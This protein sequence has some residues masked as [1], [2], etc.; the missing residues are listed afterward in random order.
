VTDLAG[1]ASSSSALEQLLAAKEVVVVC[2]A[3]GVG[4][5]TTAAALGVLAVTAVGG[6][7]LVL[8]VDPAR[9]LADAMGVG[10]LGN[11]AVRIPPEMFAGTGV[12][13]EG[14]LWAAMLDTKGGWDDLV[15]LHAPDAATRDAILGNPLYDTL[16]ARFVQSHDYVAMERLYE[17]HTSGDYDLV[18]VDTPPSRHAIDFLEAPTRMAEFFASRFLRLLIAP[19]RARIV[20]LAARPFYSLADRILGGDFVRDIAEFFLAFQSM[21]EGFIG[22][23]RAVE[24]L[25][26]EP[27]TAFVVVSTLE[28]APLSESTYLLDELARRRLPVGAVILNKALPPSLLDRDAAEA[29]AWLRSDAARAVDGDFGPPELVAN[30]LDE[31][32]ESFGRL[33]VIAEREVQH[34]GEMAGRA[35]VVVAVPQLDRDIGDLEGLLAIA[36]RL[37]AADS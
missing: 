28:P 19:K 8:T 25:L 9:R 12:H 36:D 16:T 20:N 11:D 27:R 2:G 15:R 1:P 10:A 6:R 34:R 37:R 26:T 24:R 18:I 32:G 4:K 23:A 31:I 3:G 17:L 30:V 5:T 22:R 14:E 29:S 33:R 13:P 7:V 21:Y 35:D